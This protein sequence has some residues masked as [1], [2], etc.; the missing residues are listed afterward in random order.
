[1]KKMYVLIRRDLPHHYRYVQGAHA[2]A[3][4]ALKFPE[5][6]REWNNETIVFL[7]VKTE[8]KLMLA[9]TQL[10]DSGNSVAF[11]NEPDLDN[12]LTATACFCEE[13]QMSSFRLAVSL[14][15][16]IEPTRWAE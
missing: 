14:V 8:N 4:Y 2:L 5:E 7:D 15:Q 13:T 12:Q 16:R 1:M 9:T 3:S 10:H 6:F 11:F